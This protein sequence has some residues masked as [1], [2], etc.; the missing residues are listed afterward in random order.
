LLLSYYIYIVVL[1]EKFTKGYNTSDKT[2]IYDR[3]NFIKFVGFN[4]FCISGQKNDFEYKFIFLKKLL[5]KVFFY[6]KFYFGY[7]LLFMS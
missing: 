6:R 7:I 5:N 3:V 4:L 2:L 1:K